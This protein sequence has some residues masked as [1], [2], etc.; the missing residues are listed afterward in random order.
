MKK[1]LSSLL[2][3]CGVAAALVL[4]PAQPADAAVKERVY[5]FDD[6]GAIAGQLPA[7]IAGGTR[8]GT[9]DTQPSTT[10]YGGFDPPAQVNN[11]FVPMIGSGNTARIPVY[12]SAADRPGAT[13]SNLGLLFDGVDDTLYP[14]LPATPTTPYVFDPRDFN[15][16]FDVLSQV[17]VKPTATTFPTEQFVY[18]IGNEHGAVSISTN[19]KWAFRTGTDALGYVESPV[20]VQPNVWT[21]IAIFRGG[22][23]SSLYINGSVVARDP[24]FW[25]G[26]GP[27][28]RLGSDLLAAPGTFFKGVVDNFNIGTP[29]DDSFDASVDIDYF[30]DLGITFSG[31]LGDIN[32]DNTVNNADYQV[33]SQHVGENN[34]FGVGDPGTLLRGDADQSGVID[35]YDF[36]TINDASIAAGNGAVGLAAPE[37]A[38]LT[39]ILSG[40]LL[41]AGRR[42][43]PRRF[44][45][46]Q[47]M[48]AA[49]TA[50]LLTAIAA[51]SAHAVVVVAEDFLYDGASKA[52]R[53]GG[54]FNGLEVYQGGQNGPAGT[55]GGR[56]ANLGDGIIITPNYVPPGAPPVPEPNTPFYVGDLDGDLFGPNSVL[57]R[58]FSVAGSVSPTQS[59]YFGGKFKADVLVDPA[60]NS[61]LRGCSS[62]GFVAKTGSLPCRSAIARRTSPWAFKKTC[63]SPASVPMALA[64][65]PKS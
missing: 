19:G 59:M 15:N 60:P 35:L 54:G 45:S 24:G 34:G 38:S 12:A 63:S 20:A 61:T 58:D 5:T 39:L 56:W 42:S 44:S 18:R 41:L 11:S 51:D 55:W 8:R 33:W 37:P 64:W 30:A 43:R 27:D 40:A 3:V 28:L 52:L 21:H 50:V 23:I 53:V 10:D 26:E 47:A 65:D 31:L 14:A 62:I 16:R 7:V 2:C 22:N 17:W 13:A 32:Q 36:M 57:M 49:L 46:R 4:L 6:A 48:L 29:S 25:G 1:V 9:N